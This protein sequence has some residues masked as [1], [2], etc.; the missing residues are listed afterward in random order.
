VGAAR[1]N[2]TTVSVSI[3]RPPR[4]VYAFVRDP[5]KLPQW[6][7]G[8]ARSVRR[9]GDGWIVEMPDGP[10]RLRFA[11]ANDFGVLDHYVSPA[12]GVE[13]LN[14][15]RVVPNGA[16]SE[17]MF[18]VFQQPD[19]SDAQFANDVGLVERDLRALKRVLE[20]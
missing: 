13:F 7:A 1:V 18:T 5:E 19:M 17:V 20:G 16:G 6:A 11:P 4:D 2:S 3:A 14:P 15:M 9:D 10:M 12:P 8:L